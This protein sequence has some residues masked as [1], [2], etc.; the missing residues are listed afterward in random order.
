MG[1]QRCVS[2]VAT[3][4][5]EQGVWKCS[6]KELVLVNICLGGDAM[7]GYGSDRNSFHDTPWKYV[8]SR[9]GSSRGDLVLRN[10]LFFL[11]WSRKGWR[12]VQGSKTY[13]FD[14][15]LSK[16]KSSEKGR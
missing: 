12:R 11:C 16:Q 14:N 15:D 2:F 6:G 10:Y 1:I 4:K 5:V 3:S 7:S 13:A 9:L 8:C